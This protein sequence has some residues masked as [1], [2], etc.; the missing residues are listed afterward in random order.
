MWTFDKSKK[1]YVIFSKPDI[2]IPVRIFS[3]AIPKKP[4][5]R[6]N[7]PFVSEKSWAP[8]LDTLSTR[9]SDCD[10]MNIRGVSKAIK[11]VNPD[12]SAI[13]LYL[14]FKIRK[15]T[16]IKPAIIG[17]DAAVLDPVCNTAKKI[18]GINNARENR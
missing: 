9:T 13:I 16:H 12:I 5:H 6:K 4:N 8:V 14:D 10:A 18:K 3:L 2:P 15:N 17:I 7:L 1:S 11:T